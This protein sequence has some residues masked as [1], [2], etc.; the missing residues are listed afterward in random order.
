MVG[1]FIFILGIILGSFYLCV[2][3]RLAQKEKITGR[4]KCD[5]CQHNLKW[6]ELI[7]LLSYIFQRGK[8]NYCHQKIKSEHFWVELL[9]GLSFLLGYLYL[10]NTIRFYIYLVLVSV[11]III[12]ITDLKFMIILDSPLIIA[13]VLVFILKISEIGF[14]G[15]LYGLLYGIGLMAIMYLIKLLGDFLFKRESLGGGDI[16]LSFLIGLAI[17]YPN[18]GLRMGLIALI[19]ASFLAL[20]YALVNTYIYKKN[21]LPYGPFLIASMIII[22]VFIEKFT[23]LLVFFSLN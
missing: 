10:G 7:P 21:E 16:K 6:Y 23:N 1:L 22:F 14:K 13:S 19:F 17:G 11:A 3:T 20:P 18:I 9:T 15:A 8:C 2:A 5:S 4:S 12:F